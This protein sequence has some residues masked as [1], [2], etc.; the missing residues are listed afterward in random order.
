MNDWDKILDYFAHRCGDGGPD[1]TNPNHLALLRES[2]LK[3]G[4]KEIAANEFLGNL[5]EG[6][7]PDPKPKSARSLGDRELPDGAV[8]WTGPSGGKYF[9]FPEDE[10]GGG[11]EG[12]GEAEMEPEAGEEEEPA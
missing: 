12:G 7:K 8:L 11:E 5:R 1:M 10:E 4:W 6:E 9:Y 3:F 2:L